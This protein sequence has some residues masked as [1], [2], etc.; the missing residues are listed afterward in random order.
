[1]AQKRTAMDFNVINDACSD[2]IEISI[3]NS[4]RSS[5]N[6]MLKQEPED[7]IV[8]DD[9]DDEGIYACVYFSRHKFFSLF[10]MMLHYCLNLAKSKIIAKMYD[11]KK[12]HI[13]L[14][15]TS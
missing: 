2:V 5:T 12:F 4:S 14:Y 7:I 10:K 15:L 3:N 11:I 13:T 6:K 8:I 1:M 9:S